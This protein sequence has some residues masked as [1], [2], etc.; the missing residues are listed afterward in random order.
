MESP[1]GTVEFAR[2]TAWC[3]WWIVRE[4]PAWKTISQGFSPPLCAD[5]EDDAD[6]GIREIGGLIRV[7][8]PALP[9]W[10]CEYYTKHLDQEGLEAA[11]PWARAFREVLREAD[12]QCRQQRW[13]RR[14]AFWSL[15]HRHVS[16]ALH[17]SPPPSLPGSSGLSSC[18]E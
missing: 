4:P 15:H 8:N 12:V 11:D 18:H 3:K 13:L 7:G 2:A 17:L 16:L 10:D 1:K 14:F 6:Q 5:G 9:S